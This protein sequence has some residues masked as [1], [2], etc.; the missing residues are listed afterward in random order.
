MFHE[1]N[2]FILY[3]MKRKKI[4]LIF[5]KH[6]LSADYLCFVLIIFLICL[7]FFNN[8]AL[9]WAIPV[10][11]VIFHSFE[12]WIRNVHTGRVVIVVTS[13]AANNCYVFILFKAFCHA[14]WTKVIFSR[15]LHDFLAI[16][17]NM[18]FIL[19]IDFEITN[20][21][22]LVPI[23]LVSEI[24]IT[25]NIYTTTTAVFVLFFWFGGTSNVLYLFIQFFNCIIPIFQ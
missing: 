3:K 20:L 17:I 24:Y 15:S 5:F 23:L 25:W 12:C 2:L 19:L 13:I 4:E 9:I 21:K 16:H 1:S 11:L 10:F 14:F 6:F 7:M 18:Y 8:F 22:K